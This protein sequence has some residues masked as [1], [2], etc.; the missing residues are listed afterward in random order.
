MKKIL[1]ALSICA[2]FAACNGSSSTG[3]TSD[4]T[5]VTTTDTSMMAPAPADTTMKDTTHM[6]SKDTTKK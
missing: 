4:S 3:S 6:M 5:S 1:I 2:F